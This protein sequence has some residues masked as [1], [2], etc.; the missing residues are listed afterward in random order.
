[1]TDPFEPYEKRIKELEQQ[2]DALLGYLRE[3][4][5]E[6]RVLGW[7]CSSLDEL[8]TAAIA[9]AEREVK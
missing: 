5:H 4:V 7:G 1:M 3:Y 6:S 8:A 2:R 9:A